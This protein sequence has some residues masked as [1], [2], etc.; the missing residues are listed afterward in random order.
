MKSIK[1]LAQF[2]EQSNEL[3]NSMTIEEKK[4]QIAKDC[5]KRIEI[6]QL[7]PLQ[8]AIISTKAIN[9]FRAKKTLSVKEIINDDT[10]LPTCQVC[11]KGGLFLAYVGRVNEFST[12]S[13]TLD[14]R[15]EY[16]TVND[17]EHKKLLQLFT[18]RELAHIEFAFEGRQCLRYDTESK[19]IN[20]DT[21]EIKRILNFKS[22]YFNPEI[23]LVE[24]CK[25]IIRNKGTFKLSKHYNPKKIVL[26]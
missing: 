11:A 5:I 6:G 21:L 2:I 26:I 25:N 16:N 22:K 20:F 13:L 3:F 14:T 1:N 9:T 19:P 17:D 15:N 10:M 24:I 7:E 23:R 8:G 12:L 18:A 4:M